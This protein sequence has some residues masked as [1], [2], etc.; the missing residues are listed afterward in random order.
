MFDPKQVGRLLRQDWA[1]PTDLA[2]ELYDLFTGKEQGQAAPAA[3]IKAPS[4]SADV[5]GSRD[6]QVSGASP[7]PNS[8]TVNRNNQTAQQADKAKDDFRTPVPDRQISE[9]PDAPFGR[10]P[11]SGDQRDSYPEKA[12]S[13]PTAASFPPILASKP[14]ASARGL[15]SIDT[16]NGPDFSPARPNATTSSGKIQFSHVPDEGF[17]GETQLAGVHTPDQTAPN[18]RFRPVSDD[19]DP[20]NFDGHLTRIPFN[21]SGSQAVFFGKVV[22]GQGDTYVMNLFDSPDPEE[23]PVDQQSVKIAGLDAK[24]ILP[25]D[26]LVYPVLLN[27]NGDQWFGMMALWI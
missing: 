24:E 19:Y 11:D 1:S 2:R 23:S 12:D 25:K 5:A 9:A 6:R 8:V 21:D 16:S 10:P 18:Q 13:R 17:A 4:L 22:A 7:R 15:A 14:A 27:D 3:G 20:Y 26:T